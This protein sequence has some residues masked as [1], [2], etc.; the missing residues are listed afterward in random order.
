MKSDTLTSLSQGELQGDMAYVTLGF[1]LKVKN[2]VLALL[3]SQAAQSIFLLK[4]FSVLEFE[5]RKHTV[6][7][8][9]QRDI[10]PALYS[11]TVRLLSKLALSLLWNPGKL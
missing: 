9:Y 8:F 3:S 10:S 11:E 1:N 2:R 4:P 5:P 6:P 7:A